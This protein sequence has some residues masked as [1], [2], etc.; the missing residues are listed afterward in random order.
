MSV[1][2]E[3]EGE[4]QMAGTIEAALTAALRGMDGASVSIVAGGK[5][6]QDKN[7][8]IAKVQAKQLRDPFYLDQQAKVA[9]RFALNGLTASAY[10]VR[11]RALD[12]AG[13]LMLNGI[14]R[15]V[16]RQQNPGGQS[17]KDLTAKYAAYKKR[18]HG[19]TIPIL[20]ATGDMLG[21]LRVVIQGLS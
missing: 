12:L 15:N 21:G 8:L 18:V 3:L 11:K 13:E 6:G 4:N 17:F 2:V 5:R 16:E 1:S 19:F 20:K 10:S 14:G 7:T 9:I